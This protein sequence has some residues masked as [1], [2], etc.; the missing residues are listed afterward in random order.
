MST[1]F[2]NTVG[3][4]GVFSAEGAVVTL[5]C[6]QDGLYSTCVRNV[7]RFTVD[8]YKQRTTYCTCGSMDCSTDV[9]V[10]GYSYMLRLVLLSAS[11]PFGP[12]AWS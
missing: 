2:L 4:G 9:R 6:S 10:L 3:S 5:V 7:H 11:K 8:E 1:V 12:S